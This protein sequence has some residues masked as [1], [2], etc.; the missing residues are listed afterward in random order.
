[1]LAQ[2]ICGWLVLVK[3]FAQRLK[4]GVDRT[5]NFETSTILYTWAAAVGS[6]LQTTT[7]IVS[8]NSVHVSALAL[9]WY[10]ELGAGRPL[11]GAVC[12]TACHGL[13]AHNNLCMVPYTHDELVNWSESRS[14]AG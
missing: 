11:R 14:I 8:Y 12:L 1:M 6:N 7:G 13:T 5:G 4:R 2:G 9:V 3:A 10:A